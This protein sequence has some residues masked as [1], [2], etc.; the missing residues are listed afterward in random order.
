MH[1][2]KE[3]GKTGGADRVT[4]CGLTEKVGR[5]KSEFKATYNIAHVTCVD[6]VDMA[7]EDEGE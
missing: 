1:L 2:I 6:C 7:T 4:W 3:P 5:G